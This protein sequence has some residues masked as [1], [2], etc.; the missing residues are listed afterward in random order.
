MQVQN[1]LKISFV[2]ALNDMLKFYQL[3]WGMTSG[4]RALA[5]SQLPVIHP[6]NIYFVNLFLVEN[7]FVR[8]F[9]DSNPG[10]NS[11]FNANEFKFI[12]KSLPEGLE[13]ILNKF[14]ASYPESIKLPKITN[15]VPVSNKKR[16]FFFV[17][18][19]S[20]GQTKR[21]ARYNLNSS[22]QG[23]RRLYNYYSEYK[24]NLELPRQSELF[25]LA[26]L[27]ECSSAVTDSARSNYVV[28][29]NN[30]LKTNGFIK[31]HK[32]G[33]ITVTSQSFPNDN[34][35]EEL[36]KSFRDKLKEKRTEKT[37]ARLNPT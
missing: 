33:V 17:D 25:N 26:K 11:L 24:N 32:R 4:Q 8:F 21:L 20:P 29:I 10:L 34:A 28:Y 31:I 37:K 15:L 6:N 23:I 22:V 27:G 18:S 19:E 2:K 5:I 16:S 9:V 7:K 13:K 1:E 30:F 12:I 36:L 14:F 3:S 35:L